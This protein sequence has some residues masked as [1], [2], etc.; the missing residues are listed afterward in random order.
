MKKLL[1]VSLLILGLVLF[2]CQKE[3]EVLVPE[4]KSDAISFIAKEASPFAT[5]SSSD[6]TFLS[7]REVIISNDSLDI[8]LNVSEK[9]YHSDFFTQDAQ[10]TKGAPYT[11]E[12]GDFY[13]SAF[14]NDMQPFFEKA[15]LTS[16][17]SEVSTGHYWPLPST[18]SNS[19]PALNFFGFAMKNETGSITNHTYTDAKS[20]SFHYTLPSASQNQEDALRQS[21]MLLAI[22]PE[23]TKSNGTVEMDF[24]HS[25]SALSFTAGS[26]PGY[27]KIESVK[28]TNVYSSGTCSYEYGTNGL[29]FNWTFN[30]TSPADTRADYAQS[31]IQ[32]GP[33]ENGDAIG[34]DTHTFMM[35]PQTITDASQIQITVSFDGRK[36]TITKQLNQ[37]T[38]KWLPGKL[39]T[40]KISSPDEVKI[41]V[42]DKVE[43]DSDGCPVKKDL[44]IKNAGLTYAYIRVAIAGSWVVDHVNNGVTSQLIVENWKYTDNPTTDDGEFT[45]PAGKPTVGTTINNWRLGTDGYYYYMKKVAPGETIEPLFDTYKLTAKAPISGAY[46]ELSILA[47]GVLCEHAELLYPAEILNALEK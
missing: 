40:F 27:L 41:E 38:Q 44:Q 14:Y 37:L 11:S 19:S 24:Y 33:L 42:D 2:G 16:D 36:H 46:L 45:W 4:S 28:F 3:Q 15:K 7:Y 30:S 32:D 39:Y 5:K 34:D 35:I 26:V 22:S 13:V 23:Q 29:K 9:N 43:N 21:D 47:Q 18:P 31:F 25:L 1:L 17:G 20:A 10:I 6:G 8:Y 12:I